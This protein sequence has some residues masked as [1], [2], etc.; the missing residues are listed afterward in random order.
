MAQEIRRGDAVGDEGA[1]AARGGERQ[2]EEARRRP[3]AGQGHAA[4]CRP[5]KAMKPARARQ[6]VDYLRTGYRISIRQ[7]CGALRFERSSYHYRHR[8]PEQAPLRTRIRELAE[9][10]VRYGHRRIHIY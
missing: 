3:L 7:A 9:A 5:P 10:R 1:E 6:L 8:R 4:G 2:A